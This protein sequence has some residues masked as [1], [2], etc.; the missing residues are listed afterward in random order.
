MT[1]HELREELQ[2]EKIEGRERPWGYRLLQRGPSIYLTWFFIKTP[3]TPN[4]IT[5]SSIG[6]GVLGA[7]LT[8][9]P[10]WETKL[11]GLALLYLNLLLDRVDG[12]VARYK[13]IYSL[14]GIY[15]DELNHLL[16]PPLFFICFAWGIA[17]TSGTFPPLFILAG[18]TIA[19]FMSIVIRVLHNIPYQIYLKKYVKR[20]DILAPATLE[21]PQTIEGLRKDHAGTYAILRIAHQPQDFFITLCIF[22]LTLLAE[23]YLTSYHF[24]SPF[25]SWLLVGYALFLTLVTFE[26]ALKGMITI[27]SRMQEI[28]STVHA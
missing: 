19:A 4:Q 18:G 14:K 11:I 28:D 12:E 20:R 13:K 10:A 15:G 22:A 9:S 7:C 2:R 23:R 8:A 1:I 16:I 25:T 6:I 3:F 27:T 21:T 24:F 17:F 5:L 26:T